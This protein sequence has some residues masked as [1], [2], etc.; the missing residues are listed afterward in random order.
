MPTTNPN[1]E[2]ASFSEIQTKA[3][4]VLPYEQELIALSMI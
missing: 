2:E 4:D 3:K 1:Q